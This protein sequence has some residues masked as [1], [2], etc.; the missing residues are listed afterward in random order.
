MCLFKDEFEGK[1]SH[2]K[3]CICVDIHKKRL[4]WGNYNHLLLFMLVKL[5]LSHPGVAALS[6]AG[7]KWGGLFC[8]G[9][10]EV[11]LE[12]YLGEGLVVY[13]GE[14]LADLDEPDFWS[15]AESLFL[16][17]WKVVSNLLPLMSLLTS[18][19]LSLSFWYLSL[20]PEEEEEE[21]WGDLECLTIWDILGEDLLAL[22]LEDECEEEDECLDEEWEE[23]EPEE[24][25]EGLLEEDLW[26]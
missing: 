16:G 3:S 5:S 23:E 6:N 17:I 24:E 25:D 21:D 14:A 13:F 7:T 1:F 12:P 2:K 18:S 11:E 9:L 19:I 10:L 15:D 8:L 22:E 26:W 4:G 20:D